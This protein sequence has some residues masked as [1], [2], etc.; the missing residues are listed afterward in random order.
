[1]HE[2]IHRWSDGYGASLTFTYIPA[3]GDPEPFAYVTHEREG[4]DVS[5]VFATA[6]DLRELAAAALAMAD[7]L[8]GQAND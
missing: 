2:L 8:D 1:M 5:D 7:A 3:L 4:S 6:S